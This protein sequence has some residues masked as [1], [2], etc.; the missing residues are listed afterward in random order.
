VLYRD[1]GSALDAVEEGCTV[2][3]DEQCDGSVGA[4]FFASLSAYDDQGNEITFKG[5]GGSPDETGETALDAMIMDG[6][7]VR[8]SCYSAK[9]LKTCNFI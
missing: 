9:N 1:G 4:L 2:C 5:F 8:S 7:D 6:Y 3:E